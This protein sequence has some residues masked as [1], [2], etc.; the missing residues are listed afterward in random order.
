MRKV[1]CSIVMLWVRKV[2]CLIVTLLSRANKRYL[3]LMLLSRAVCSL[4]F[5]AHSLIITLLM[6]RVM[7][8]IVT[9]L[10]RAKIRYGIVAR[11]L[12]VTFT[13]MIRSSVAQLNS[14][15]VMRRFFIFHR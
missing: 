13:I 7:C 14:K 9:L 6:R 10:S 15:R 12:T 3:I 8:L 5:D 2:R 4:R 11:S 1:R